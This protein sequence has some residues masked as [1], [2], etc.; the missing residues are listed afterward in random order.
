MNDS[1]EI[2]RH[3]AHRGD[4]ITKIE[5]EDVYNKVKEIWRKGLEV[6]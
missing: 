5:P 6:A 1:F 3:L 2:V 4:F